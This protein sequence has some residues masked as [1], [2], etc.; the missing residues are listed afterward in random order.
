V[1]VGEPATFTITRTGSTSQ[2]LS[3]P[4]VTTGT[5]NG[6]ASAG[7]DY[8]TLPPSVLIPVGRKSV[9]VQV[10]PLQDQLAE[11]NETVTLTL[12]GS[13][14]G[15]PNAAT[16]VIEDDEADPLLAAH[17]TFDETS[18]AAAR[19]ISGHGRHGT[20]QPGSLGPKRF[21]GMVSGALSF[22]EVD[23]R[24]IVPN[25]DYTSSGAFTISFW[26]RAGP[27]TQSSTQYLY[28]HG[29]V[30][31]ANSI[32]IYRWEASN[33]LRTRVRFQNDIVSSIVLDVEKN[34][35]DSQWHFY[36]LTVEASGGYGRVYIDGQLGAANLLAGDR[37]APT[38]N[39]FLGARHDLS[40]TR[41]FAGALDDVMIQSRGL[42]GQEVQLLMAATRGDA[43]SYGAGC[44]TSNLLRPVHSISGRTALGRTSHFQV[45]QA[46]PGKLGAIYFGVSRSRWQSLTLPFDM[47]PW[48]APGC[49]LLQNL[50]YSLGLSLSN[51]SGSMPITVPNDIALRGFRAYSQVM[52]VDR[53]AN[54]AGFAVSNGLE[55]VIGG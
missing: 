43:R 40:A 3:V 51:G 47:A 5:A 30:N 54:P 8:R 33:L 28:S 27:S 49:V 31:S 29:S 22:D 52:V 44:A 38:T 18:G 37:L 39:I 11:G 25:F 50:T 7:Q 55:L 4:F 21:A 1:E 35:M 10:R 17:W 12:T 9:D 20:L 41:F 48:G 23:D 2:V 46:A 34:F 36:A 32:N 13:N 6:T 15:W 19:D 53:N 16:A 45:T 14:I 24:V 26:F 42:T